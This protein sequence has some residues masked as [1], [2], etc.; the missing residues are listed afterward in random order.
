MADAQTSARWYIVVAMGR[1][2]GHLALGI[3]KAAA[4]PL[5]LIPEEFEDRAVTL[6]E[7]CDIIE[8][9]II[10]RGVLGRD[11]GV[12]ILAEGLVESMTPEHRDQ[13]FGGDGDDRDEHGH[14]KLADIEFGKTVR[15]V[16]RKRFKERS[17]NMTVINKNL[18]YELRCAD[19]IPY[20]AEYTRDLGYGAVCFLLDGG[21][22]AIITF[23]GGVLKPLPFDEMLDPKTGRPRLRLVDIT[24]ESYQVARKYMIRL[25]ARDREDSERFQRLAQAANMTP[26]Q[27]EAKFGY[28]MT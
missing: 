25:D 28:L 19:P 18:G 4:V 11:H 20:D 21:R 8:G 24:G 7:I 6:D 12:V 14:I 3:G 2:A 9:A 15:D 23:H 17:Q 27:F 1:K 26:A 13:V 5:T 10:K 22:G 16:L